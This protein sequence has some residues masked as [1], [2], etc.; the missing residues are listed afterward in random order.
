MAAN[1]PISGWRSMQ[2]LRKLAIDILGSQ[3]FVSD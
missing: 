1:V 3:R 2:L